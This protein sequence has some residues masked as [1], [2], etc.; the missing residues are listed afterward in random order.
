MLQ[1]RERECGDDPLKIGFPSVDTCLAVVLQTTAEL[2]GW[3]S[4]NT[5]TPVTVANSG[6]LRAYAAAHAG[7]APVHLYIATNR[8]NHA[9]DWRTELTA[10]AG[11]LLYH[12]PATAIDLHVNDEGVY[13]QFE[14]D[15]A[16]RTCDVFYKRNSK[17][18]YESGKTRLHVDSVRH[19]RLLTG[20]LDFGH[21]FTPVGGDGK[22]TVYTTVTTN[23]QSAKGKL[24]KVGWNRRNTI[25][26]P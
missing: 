12:G 26:I 7:G 17:V 19:R 3:H 5:D 22:A 25:T 23:D 4:L 1:L 10:I 13:V 2:V 9:R 8:A 6:K 24:N 21:L 18:D 15:A 20:A 16:S 11:G 14:R